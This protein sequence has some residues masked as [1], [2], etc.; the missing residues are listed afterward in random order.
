MNSF[1][2]LKQ[3]RQKM[4]LMVVDMLLLLKGENI[5]LIIGQRN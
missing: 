3:T 1:S 2:F 4:Y 5:A